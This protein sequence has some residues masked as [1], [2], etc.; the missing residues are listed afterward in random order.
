[1]VILA[2]TDFKKIHQHPAPYTPVELHEKIRSI[3]L[4]GGPL[5]GMNVIPQS[6]TEVKVFP[7]S[8]LTPDRAQGGGI[9]VEILNTITVP[10]DPSMPTPALLYALTNDE[11]DDDVVIGIVDEVTFPDGAIVLAELTTSGKWFRRHTLAI[12]ELHR[13]RH[14]GLNGDTILLAVGGTPGEDVVIR[15]FEFD[16][17]EIL[18]VMAW[19]DGLRFKH[20][21]AADYPKWEETGRVKIVVTDGAGAAPVAF[22]AVDPVEVMSN[23]DIIFQSEQLGN[24]S[25]SLFSYPTGQTIVVGSKEL[26]VFK[27]GLLL[28]PDDVTEGYT[29]GTTSVTLDFVPSS[30]VEIALVKISPVLF[31]EKFTATAGQTT[32]N[33]ALNAYRTGARQL[34]VF[35][36][37]KKKIFPNDYDETNGEQF[38][39]LAGL[40]VGQIV[41]VMAIRSASTG[42][43][44]SIKVTGPIT[45]GGEGE[46]VTLGFDVDQID[47]QVTPIQI[48]VAGDIGAD[49]GRF[50]RQKHIHKEAHPLAL[51]GD[52]GLPL[53]G[54]TAGVINRGARVDHAHPSL[55]ASTQSNRSR[56]YHLELQETFP[57]PQDSEVLTLLP[58]E[59]IHP[60]GVSNLLGHRSYA[61]Y[62]SHGVGG[63]GPHTFKSGMRVRMSV[64][65]DYAGGGIEMQLKYRLDRDVTGDEA[66][67]FTIY[68]RADDAVIFG[69]QQVTLTVPTDQTGGVFIL[70]DGSSGFSPSIVMDESTLGPG[71]FI[72]IDIVRVSDDGDDNLGPDVLAQTILLK[73][74]G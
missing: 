51:P 47:A 68:G 23:R 43:I 21:Y 31:R 26:L 4:Q 55:A 13:A 27:D 65:L 30:G 25:A 64:P 40:T 39:F 41:E 69:P 3:F 33:L 59:V 7:G 70:A 17:A 12:G 34:M 38:K 72:V 15:R 57:V 73:Y 2:S 24:G 46:E 61:F 45:G 35:V 48:A 32:F 50:A 6:A 66:A 14:G 42:G 29:E 20:S 16:A 60:T 49:E 10:V 52:L 53:G 22:T 5:K 71:D 44:Q 36:D 56:E 11:I 58:G 37:G 1:M 54:A 67:I 18:S 62:G 63:A 74:T 8:F 19:G 28:D 9:T